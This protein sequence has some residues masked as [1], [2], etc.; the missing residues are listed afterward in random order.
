MRARHVLALALAGCGVKLA[1]P[2]T[3]D[4]TTTQPDSGA[5]NDN[6]PDAGSASA[7][8]AAAPID[9][10]PDAV[11]TLTA[12]DFITQYGD[13]QCAEAFTC[14]SSFP[15]NASEF[16]ND[17]GTDQ[18]NC[19]A[20]ALAYYNPSKVET[21]IVSAAIVYTPADATTCLATIVFGTCANFWQTGGTYP[22][23][24]NT[25]LVGSVANGG[26]CVTDFECQSLF[27][28]NS[29]NCQN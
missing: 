9:S 4:N 19:N 10:A 21:D 2:P 13:L 15:G 11:M 29:G 16:E 25:A 12:T 28:N 23:A 6:L 7:S 1:S 26:G 5:F 17:W 8:D 24:C 22:A 3:D 18:T 27:C 20:L 14:Q